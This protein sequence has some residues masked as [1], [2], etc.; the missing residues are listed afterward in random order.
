MNKQAQLLRSICEL[1]F[2]SYIVSQRENSL[3]FGLEAP[4]NQR[5]I[6]YGKLCD[7][8]YGFDGLIQMFFLNSPCDPYNIRDSSSLWIPR[9]RVPPFWH[10]LRMNYSGVGAFPSRRNRNVGWPTSP[11]LREDSQYSFTVE[12]NVPN[13]PILG[14]SLHRKSKPVALERLNVFSLNT[15]P[16]LSESFY[17]HPLHCQF[18]RQ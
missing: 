3:S 11:Y 1:G 8:G 5:E 7:S 12:V 9:Y 13:Y 17:I 18:G 10:L 16:E 2:T 4:M 14:R 6:S 15:M